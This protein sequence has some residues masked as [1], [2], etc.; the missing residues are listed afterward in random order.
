M[1]SAPSEVTRIIATHAH[2]DHVG[3]LNDL[4]GRTGAR[5]AVHEHD[6]AYV[7]E[8]KGPM[9][10]TTTLG[11][12]LFR[13]NRRATPTQVDEELTDGQVIA[14]T[15]QTA[16]VL[17]EVDYDVAAFTHGPEIRDNAREAIR[18]FLR[19]KAGGQ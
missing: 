2:P 6:V 12:R 17:G 1:G 11:G 15:T 7:R 19:D 8:G 13:H 14:M 16:Q 4:H 3:G 5:V 9:L 10:D 18:G